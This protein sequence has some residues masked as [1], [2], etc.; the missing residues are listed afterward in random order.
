MMKYIKVFFIVLLSVVGLQ[1]Y[2]QELEQPTVDEESD[3]SFGAN[4]GFSNKYLWRGM[5]F[6]NGL[7]F[8]P[9]VFVG[10]R[11]FSINLWSNTTL[12][13]KKG[14]NA[15]EI[16]IT[17]DYYHS[18]SYLDVET[19]FSYYY[20]IDQEEEPNTLEWN[21]SAFYPVGDFTLSSG[22]NV[23]ILENRGAS[24][25][26]VALDYE[27]ELNE[28]FTVSGKVLAGLGSGKFNENNFDVK[29]GAMN[30]VG[31]NIG[32]SYNFLADFYADVN[33]Y[34]NL[35]VDKELKNSDIVKGVSSNAFELILRK[36]F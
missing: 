2:S 28:K 26:E 16:D 21:V 8:Q 13:D 7:V 20:F 5:V 22:L 29:K 34:Q 12:Y 6:N 23:D 18:F 36:E 10:W 25:L 33:F 17:L 27:R 32:F 24:Y 4:A 31:G 35:F 3:W 30:L 14:V 9:E 11:D 19:Y 1:L 15:H